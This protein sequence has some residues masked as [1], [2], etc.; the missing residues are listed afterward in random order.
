MNAIHVLE[1]KESINTLL[2]IADNPGCTRQDVMYY[3][4]ETKA[5]P[6]FLRIVDYV[7]CGLVISDRNEDDEIVLR[8][9]ESGM[10]LADCIRNI[11]STLNPEPIVEDL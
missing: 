7:N 5:R 3:Q 4:S 8:L 11:D 2:I 9:S 6:R 10:K 1:R